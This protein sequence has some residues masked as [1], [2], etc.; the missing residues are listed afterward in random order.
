[1]K[2]LYSLILASGTKEALFAALWLALDEAPGTFA[3]VDFASLR[4]TAA[5]FGVALSESQIRKRVKEL[6]KLDVLAVVPRRERGRF[7][8]LVFQPAP[9]KVAT[10]PKPEPAT[11]LFD[12][13]FGKG[14]ESFVGD[15]AAP[16]PRYR[17]NSASAPVG[18]DALA[19]LRATSDSAAVSETETVAQSIAES[20]ESIRDRARLEPLYRVESENVQTPEFATCAASSSAVEAARN[21][22]ETPNRFAIERGPSGTFDAQE[23]III[24]QERNQER[25]RPGRFGE[26]AKGAVAESDEASAFGWSAANVRDYVDFAAPETVALRAEVAKIVW[27]RG[28]RPDLVDRLTAAIRLRLPGLTRLDDLRAIDREARDAVALY[29]RSKGFAGRAKRWQT[30]NLALRAIYEAAGCEYP[31]TRRGYEPTPFAG[32]SIPRRSKRVA[33]S[34]NTETRSVDELLSV[35]AGFEPSELDLPFADFSRLVARRRGIADA[36]ESRGVAL[37]IRNALRELAK[38]ELATA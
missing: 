5:R 26:A 11:P 22:A 36:C 38:R 17:A 13:A 35:A 30:T 1:M 33:E 20:G 6:E 21:R 34:K 7:D 3:D 10:A 18:R 32:A 19:Q 29:D 4:T 14:V 23:R 24:N 15:G 12:A 27:E 25:K 31:S 2:A 37:E 9:S 8:L 16:D 28:V